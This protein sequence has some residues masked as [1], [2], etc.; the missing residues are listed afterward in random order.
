MDTM[1]NGNHNREGEMDF[2]FEGKI[3]AILAAKG[4]HGWDI[5]RFARELAK[6]KGAPVT[7]SA[8]TLLMQSKNPTTKTVRWVSDALKVSPAYFFT[9]RIRTRKKK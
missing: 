9:G 2:N 3:K 8:T 7:P 6:I 4:K 1:R 5:C